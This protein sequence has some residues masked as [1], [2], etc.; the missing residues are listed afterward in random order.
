LG[1]GLQELERL[2]LE[3]HRDRADIPADELA[4][5]E[6]LVA[7]RTAARE[8]RDWGRADRLR[9]ELD[10]LGVQVTDTPTGP[11]WSLR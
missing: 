10:G 7:E 5:I 8:A 9:A 2:D 4:A 1:L 6:H 3:P 11:D